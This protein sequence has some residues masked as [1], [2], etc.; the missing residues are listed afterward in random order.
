MK[1]NL[2]L[3]ILSIFSFGLTYAQSDFQLA[4]LQLPDVERRVFQFNA[5]ANQESANTWDG[6]TTN[7]YSGNLLLHPSYTGYKN[8]R[9]RQS[10]SSASFSIK[11]TLANRNDQLLQ[12]DS[13]RSTRSFALPTRAKYSTSQYFYNSN[14][15]FVGIGTQ[16]S[17]GLSNFTS[18][19]GTSRSK[20]YSYALSGYAPVSAGKGRID[21]IDQGHVAFFMMKDL[22]KQLEFDR[23]ISTQDYVELSALIATLRRIRN[24]DARLRRI[25]Q[26]NEIDS[27]FKEKGLLKET[28]GAFFTTVYDNYFFMGQTISRFNGKRFMV[29]VNPGAHFMNSF[30][31]S[32]IYSQANSNLRRTLNLRLVYEKYTQINNNWQK[33]VSYGV[34]VR[35]VSDSSW[36]WHSDVVQ[37]NSSSSREAGS[38][39]TAKHQMWFFPSSR[40]ALNGGVE[41]GIYYN[42]LVSNAAKDLYMEVVPYFSMEYYVS[43]ATRL[44]MSFSMQFNQ[45]L[46]QTPIHYETGLESAFR[47][48]L[49]HNLF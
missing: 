40:T 7:N 20:G 45:Q 13:L 29:E 32:D 16:L 35:S 14:Y 11:P 37:R 5:T 24:F 26:M 21:P 3:S 34:G 44:N 23:E 25:E 18:R 48:S 33:Y 1:R 9:Y 6:L 46:M 27:F 36:L 47:I 31:K 22:E 19:A 8:H 4:D 28:G 42:G 2:L 41:T 30:T 17:T 49:L 38:F 39:A 12:P 43:P 15:F 10:F